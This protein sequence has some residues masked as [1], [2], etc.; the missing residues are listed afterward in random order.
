MHGRYTIGDLMLWTHCP[1][2]KVVIFL[3]SKVLCLLSERRI[4]GVR[5]KYRKW[6]TDENAIKEVFTDDQYQLHLFSL[7]TDSVI[8]D[9]G[10]NIGCFTIRVANMVKGV[11]V[12]SYEPEDYNFLILQRNMKINRLNN[13]YLFKK[14]LSGKEGERKLFLSSSNVGAHSISDKI[15]DKYVTIDCVTLK[16]VLTENA[17]DRVAL[18]KLD[19]EG[20]EYEILYGASNDYLGRIDNI[21][22]KYHKTE[23]TL[24]DIE[25]L[26]TFL[27]ESGFKVEV[28]QPLASHQGI[29]YFSRMS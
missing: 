19:C 4:E 14:G 29:A 10:A 15:S 27:A 18:L 6:T 3:Q 23:G 12:L 17:I 11:K 1:L 9:A 22:L 5:I 8:I 16:D 7:K 2:I 28:L 25:H 13:V 26:T 20:A 24:N 21:V